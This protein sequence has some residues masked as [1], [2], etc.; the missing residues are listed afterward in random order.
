MERTGRSWKLPAVPTNIVDVTG[1]GNAYCGGFTVGLG[2]GLDPLE[3][4]LQSVVS[5]SFAI[6]QIGIPCWDDSQPTEA[7]KR[8]EW[9]R[10]RVEEIVNPV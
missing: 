5:A 2:E 7:K 10:Q 9:A 4:A 1:A 3:A 6:E 8:V